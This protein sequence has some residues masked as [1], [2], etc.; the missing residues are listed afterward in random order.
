MKRGLLWLALVDL[1]QA[2]PRSSLAALAIAAA[3]LAV[4]G[5]IEKRNISDLLG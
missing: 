4:G 2:W 3:I 1:R 5:E